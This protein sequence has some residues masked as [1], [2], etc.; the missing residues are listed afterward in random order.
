MYTFQLQFTDNQSSQNVLVFS[1][2]EQFLRNTFKIGTQRRV[3]GDSLTK[4]I[5]PKNLLP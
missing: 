1:W 4:P 3:T 5:L 2:V